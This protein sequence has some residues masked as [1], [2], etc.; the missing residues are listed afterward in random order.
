MQDVRANPA[1]ANSSKG[2]K[3]EQDLAQLQDMMDAQAWADAI[4]Q[5][6]AVVT[7]AQGLLQTAAVS[8]GGPPWPLIG[9]TVLLAGGIGYV[10]LARKKT[11][12]KSD[13]GGTAYQPS[14]SESAPSAAP[15]DGKKL[16]RQE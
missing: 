4:T 1:L 10:L 16:S 7:E 11:A 5:A 15:N 8:G 13:D 14:L 3:L 9:S 2:Q 12:P 6:A